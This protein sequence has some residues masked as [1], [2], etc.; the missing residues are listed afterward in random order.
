MSFYIL[1]AGGAFELTAQVVGGIAAI[2]TVAKANESEDT[3]ERNS[4]RAAAAFL[5]LGIAFIILTMIALFIN[6]AAKGCKKGRNVFLIIF[7]VLFLICYIIALVILYVFMK[8]KEAA[9]DGA[10]AAALRAAFVMPLV[11]LALH[12]VAYILIYIV[13]GRKLRKLK[14]VCKQIPKQ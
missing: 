12:V 13:V 10:G 6:S 8:K 9:G 2:I 4:L 7:F 1:I 14:K 11:A 3:N 5:G